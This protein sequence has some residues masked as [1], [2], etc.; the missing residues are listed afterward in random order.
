MHPIPV[1]LIPDP[2]LKVFL[3][4][5]LDKDL[6]CCRSGMIFSEPNPPFHLISDPT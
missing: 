4:L 1:F 5:D 2:A 6:Q 3:S